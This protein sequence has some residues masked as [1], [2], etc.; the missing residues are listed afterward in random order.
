M[1]F[2]NSMLETTACP[3]LNITLFRGSTIL[4]YC[5]CKLPILTPIASVPS[6]PTIFLW[7][8]FLG[9]VKL[10]LIVMDLTKSNNPNT[11]MV[12]ILNIKLIML[13]SLEQITNESV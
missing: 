1:T 12:M 4:F 3:T 5:L 11:M 9:K 7:I 13:F 10:L 2:L 8:I 6:G